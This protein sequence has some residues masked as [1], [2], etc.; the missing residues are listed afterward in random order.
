MN[1]SRSR[2]NAFENVRNFYDARLSAREVGEEFLENHVVL[3]ACG[4]LPKRMRAL[5][6]ACTALLLT[7]GASATPTTITFTELPNQIADGVS[8]LGVSFDFKI[9]GVDS[10]D[11]RFNFPGPGTTTFTADPGL[12]GNSLGTLSLSFASPISSLSFG[13]ALNTT[14]TLASGFSVTLFDPG[15][16]PLSTTPVGV[17]PGAFTFSSGQFNY[18]GGP[19]SLAVITFNSAAASRFS[20]D[21]LSFEAAASVPEGGS[22]IW[23]LA[24]GLLCIAAM[25][26]KLSSRA[27]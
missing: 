25:K 9:G 11:A 7:L 18:S 14:A 3:E 8:L 20:L 10:V 1:L 5:L 26:L 21:N 13:A 22:T 19:V 15:F 24:I 2:L 23:T 6:T 4:L 12:E 27:R 17:T 16:L